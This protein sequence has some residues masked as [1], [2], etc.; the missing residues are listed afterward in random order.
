[1]LFSAM[2]HTD[3]ISF[4]SQK[5]QGLYGLQNVEEFVDKKKNEDIEN[6]Y[7]WIIAA[8]VKIVT[9]H[10]CSAGSTVLC[11]KAV[12]SAKFAKIKI[13]IQQ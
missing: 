11:R 4:A 7:G 2:Q 3:I 13:G 6:L 9:K 8:N 5:Y 10:G 12:T 1:M